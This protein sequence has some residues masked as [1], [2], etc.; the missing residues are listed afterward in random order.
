MFWF[1][2]VLVK[3]GYQAIKYGQGSAAGKDVPLKYVCIG[4]T[5]RRMSLKYTAAS[6]VHIISQRKL[7]LPIENT[8]RRNKDLQSREVRDERTGNSS[9][10]TEK[11]VVRKIEREKKKKKHLPLRPNGTP[12][13]QRYSATP[14]NA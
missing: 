4:D 10:R 5:C 8:G 2:R 7:G 13:S 9:D 3:V 14:R 12:A 1:C 6:A 11:T